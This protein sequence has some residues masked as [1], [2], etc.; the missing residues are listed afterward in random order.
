MAQAL[1]H[2][3]LLTLSL[4]LPTLLAV[5]LPELQLCASTTFLNKQLTKFGPTIEK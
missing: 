1:P 3:I 5:Y 2:S 4:L